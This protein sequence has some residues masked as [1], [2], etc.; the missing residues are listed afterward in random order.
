MIIRSTR[1]L[2]E[3]GLQP[4]TVHIRGGK[5]ER[6]GNLT[7]GVDVTDAGSDIIMPGLI[8]THVHVNEPGRTEWEGFATATRAAAAGGVTTI[9]D[10]PL[11]SIPATTTRDALC[12]K[13]ASAIQ[14]ANVN[15]G[16][17]GGVVP[18][19]ADE[20]PVLHRE[21]IRLFK[22]FLVPS[23]V[24]EFPSVVEADLHL[25]MPVLT[26][27]DATLLVHAELPEHINVKVS[28][29]PRRYTT[30]QSSRPAS[31]ET[32][33]IAMI[34]RLAAQ[35][36][37]RVHIVHVSSPASLPQIN[38]ARQRGVRITCETCPHYL[39]F[40]AEEI[41]DGAT[42]FKCAPPI[43]DEAERNMLWDAV[44]NGEIDMIVSDHSPCP[45]DLKAPES[46]DFFQAWGGIASLQ[47]GLPAVWTVAS[48][49]CP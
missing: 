44:L 35:Y 24:E 38:D 47:L 3:S 10:M 45:P 27:L 36:K 25:A 43:R 42:V 40:T 19:N 23:G 13:R 11:N 4:A 29:D 7:D 39:S 32:E 9:F 26:E 48:A 18:G 28:G 14:S 2:T 21:G 46:G 31:A 8:D 6:I 22:C 49:V 41:P 15:V 16:F 30:Y 37:T 34:I 5:I 1:V 20:L 33:A 12:V 17:I